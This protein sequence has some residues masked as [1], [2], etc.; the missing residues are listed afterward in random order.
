MYGVMSVRKA[1]VLWQRCYVQ[2]D[3]VDGVLSIAPSPTSHDV[4]IVPLEGVDLQ[5]PA[6]LRLTLMCAQHGG[7]CVHL[8]TDTEEQHREWVRAILTAQAGASPASSPIATAGEWKGKASFRSTASSPLPMRVVRFRIVNVAGV[9]PPLPLC[10]ETAAGGCAD[11]VDCS[12]SS[13]PGDGAD[14]PGCGPHP[15]LRVKGS[16]RRSRA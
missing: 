6:P 16:P 11:G 12:R 3:E 15:I 5:Q 14:A 10:S 9:L 4:K 2:L 8:R 13:S 7:R 1:L